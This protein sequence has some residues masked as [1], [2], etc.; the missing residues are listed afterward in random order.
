[1]DKHTHVIIGTGPLG[2]SL[3]RELR[4]RG[5]RD[6]RMVNRSGRI[7]GEEQVGVIKGDAANI[8]DAIAICE[9]ASVVYHCAQPGYLNWPKQFPAIT[10]G[11]LDG[12]A[13][14]G[15]RLVYADN[16]YMYGRVHGPLKESLPYRAE[17][18]KGTTRARMAQLLLDA[19]KAGK[20]RVAIGRASDFYGP[21]VT[22]S[23]LG[24]RVFGHALSGKP[25]D[26]LGNLD[27][28]HTYTYI[29]DFARG[30][31]ILGQEDRALGESWHVPSAPTMTTGQLLQIIFEQSGSKPKVRASSRGMVSLLSL[32]HPMM[33]E[34]R[35]I[36]YE[37]EQP[38]FVDHGKFVE[39]FGE[40][41]TTP[42]QEAVRRT[43]EW[44]RNVL[45]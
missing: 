11:I 18:P 45:S 12:A 37:F 20:A 38:Y 22:Q 1:M 36:M 23:F 13:A 40:L 8:A 4:G 43:L 41:A 31:A 5:V 15:A 14:A 42:H 25:V 21:G 26:V 44:Y 30:L 6:I 39:A 10:K 29:D 17:G 16:L 28:P 35:E 32:F 33:R 9:N 7:R 34:I 27:M 3:M 24:E 2:M 19:H